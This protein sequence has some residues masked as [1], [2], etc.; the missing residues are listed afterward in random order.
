MVQ[1]FSCVPL[2][3]LEPTGDE[4]SYGTHPCYA[5]CIRHPLVRFCLTPVRLLPF[6]AGQFATTSPNRR[7]PLRR[8]SLQYQPNGDDIAHSQRGK[9]AHIRQFLHPYL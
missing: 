5:A 1:N 7:L 3:D 4:L 9:A 8:L 2:R 6:A